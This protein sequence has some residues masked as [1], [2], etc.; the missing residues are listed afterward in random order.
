MTILN[1]CLG[2]VFPGPGRG[3]SRE[4]LLVRLS[5]AEVWASEFLRGALQGWSGGGKAV[6]TE[7]SC[8]WEGVGKDPVGDWWW[9]TWLL[10]PSHTLSSRGPPASSSAVGLLFMMVTKHTAR[11]CRAFK[12]AHFLW[13]TLP[14]VHFAWDD[15]KCSKE[16]QS[17]P[18]LF[19]A[20]LF[21]QII[22]SP[23]SE[24]ALG[25]MYRVKFAVGTWIWISWLLC[26]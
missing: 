21:G 15:G 3:V 5:D 2:E 19:I 7:H 16:E 20:S 26:N 24:R 10:H 25:C 1:N 18:S 17:F 22:R 6:P 9:G 23:P 13:L 8:F 12:R 14:D 4:V 11:D